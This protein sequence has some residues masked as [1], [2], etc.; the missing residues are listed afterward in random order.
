[1]THPCILLVQ[2]AKTKTTEQLAAE[3]ALAAEESAKQAA[4]ASEALRAVIA[5]EL[6]CLLGRALQ[7]FKSSQAVSAFLH[8]KR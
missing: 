4:A 8:Q 6:V 3:A 1:M 5:A 7:R 2:K